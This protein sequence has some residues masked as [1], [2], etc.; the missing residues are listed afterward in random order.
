MYRNKNDFA[1]EPDV[2]GHDSGGNTGISSDWAVPWS[3]LMMVMFVLFVVMF[4][5]AAKKEHVKVLF[6]PD[7]TEAQATGDEQLTVKPMEVLI[8]QISA[9]TSMANSR[10]GNI[11]FDDHTVLFKSVNNDVSVSEEDGALRMVIRGKS[12][13]SAGKTGYNKDADEYLEELARIMDVTTGP[14]TIIGFAD[15]KEAKG[16]DSFTLSAKRAASVAKYFLDIAYIKPERFEIIG[17]GIYQ[18]EAPS[19]KGFDVSRNRRVEIVIK[20]ELDI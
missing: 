1:H 16:I 12:F 4:T 5:F 2:F 6:S 19:T 9:H 8:G 15:K 13:F 11:V 17:K 18:P 20:Q 14:V 3:D 7:K 10:G